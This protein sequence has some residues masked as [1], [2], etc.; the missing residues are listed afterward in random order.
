ML[1]KI[2]IFPELRRKITQPTPL[3]TFSY[4]NSI[5]KYIIKIIK[6]I[7]MIKAILSFFVGSPSIPRNSANI[8][9][10]YFILNNYIFTFNR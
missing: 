2:M 8:D 10:I 4:L 6:I 5:I 9:N 1:N 3:Y 7:T